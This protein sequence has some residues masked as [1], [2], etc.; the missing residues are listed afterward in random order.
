MTARRSRFA[1]PRL[2]LGGGALVLGLALLALAVACKSSPQPSANEVLTS[3][4]TDLR[5]FVRK[6]V[7]DPERQALLLEQVDQLEGVL[8]E[9]NERIQT[10]SRDVQ[11][12]NADHGATAEQLFQVHADFEDER[13]RIR[14][15]VMDVH[16]AMVAQTTPWEWKKIHDAEVEAVK[17]GERSD[18]AEYE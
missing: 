11:A 7:A 12:L 14:D 5:R 15:A 4:V 6:S 17:I 1:R 13:R 10:F 16:F 3:H 9:L 8:I 2:G 18:V